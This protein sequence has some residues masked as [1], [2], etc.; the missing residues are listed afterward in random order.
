M[1]SRK[2]KNSNVQ[3]TQQQGS[4]NSSAIGSNKKSQYMTKAEYEQSQKQNSFANKINNLATNLINANERVQEEYRKWQNSPEYVSAMKDAVVENTRQ[5]AGAHRQAMANYQKWQ[6]E[7]Q[8]K[9]QNSPEYVNAVKD[10]IVENSRQRAGY[11]RMQVGNINRRYEQ[12]W[13]NYLNSP[14]YVDYMKNA[15]L[16]NNKQRYANMRQAQAAAYEK[17]KRSPELAETVRDMM[18]E[19]SR[20]QA[21]RQRSLMGLYDW[22]NRSTDPSE[23]YNA[24]SKE[25]RGTWLRPANNRDFNDIVSMRNVDQYVSQNPFDLEAEQQKLEEYKGLK[26]QANEQKRYRT[27]ELNRTRPKKT[28]EELQQERLELV[29]IENQL[30]RYENLDNFGLTYNNG[31]E[32]VTLKKRPDDYDDRTRDEYDIYLYDALHGKGSYDQRMY[33]INTQAETDAFMEEMDDLWD[34]LENGTLHEL[35]AS[36]PLAARKAEILWDT[37]RYDA[38]IEEQDILGRYYQDQIDEQEARI[39]FV[40]GYEDL[41]SEQGAVTMGSYVPENDRGRDDP[42][43][44]VYYYE[45]GVLTDDPHRIY[46]FINKGKEYH[47][48]YAGKEDKD[49]PV[50]SE[51]SYAALMNKEEKEI[52]NDYYN[53]GQYDEAK[54][55]LHGLM[56]YL[57]DR[58]GAYEKI[59]T[60]ETAR[61]YPF[62]SSL[63]IQGMNFADTY[64][65]IPRTVAGWLGD[66]SVDNPN[67]AWYAPAKQAE[68]LQT[69]VSNKIIEDVGERYGKIA[70]NAYQSGMSVVRNMINAKMA[71]ASGL[72]DKAAEVYGL[73]RFG[74]QI[75]QESTYKYLAETHDYNTSVGLGI[76][77]AALETAEEMLPYETMLNNTGRW[78]I[79]VFFNGLSE[80]AEEYTGATVGEKIKGWVRG[81]DEVVKRG[82]EIYMA[83]GYYKDGKWVEIDKADK[84]RAIYEADAQAVREYRENVVS[85]AMGGFLGGS[86]GAA[87]NAQKYQQATKQQGQQIQGAENNYK[88]KSGAD[89]LVELGLQMKP[90]TEARALATEIQE[91]QQK[92]KKP[93]NYKVGKLY[94][95]IYMEVGEQRSA[96]IKETAQRQVRDQLIQKGMTTDMADRFAGI[97]SENILTGEK[98]SKEDMQ[99]LAEDERAIDLWKEYNT[100]AGEEVTNNWKSLI[101]SIEE[102]TSEQDATISRL[103]NMTRSKVAGTSAADAEVNRAIRNTNSSTEAVDYMAKYSS[104]IFSE[105]YAQQAKEILDSDEQAKNSKTFVD[106]AMRIRLA[107]MTQNEQIPDTN[108]SS[109][110]AQ[111][112]Y[113]AARA[114]F[115]ENE[116]LRLNDQTKVTPG[117]GT[118]TFEGTQYGTSAWQEKISQF[119]RNT[120][121]Q[122]GAVAEIARRFGNQVEFINEKDRKMVNG[123]EIGENGQIVIN[124]ASTEWRDHSMM[125]T[126]AHEMTHWLEHNSWEGYNELRGFIISNLRK[127]GMN[128]E[129]ALMNTI[130]NQERVRTE[131][132]ARTGKQSTITTLNIND[133]MAELVAKSSEGILTSNEIKNQLAK[134]NPGLY[135]NVRKAVRNI[136]AR[137]NEAL[138]GIDDSLSEEAKLLRNQTEEIA[139]RWLSAR[140]EALGKEEEGTETAETKQLSV[141]ERKQTIDLAEALKNPELFNDY[142]TYANLIKKDPIVLTDLS[143][144]AINTRSMDK[145]A[146]R[147]AVLNAGVNNAATVGQTKNGMFYVHVGDTGTDVRIN[148]N[149]LRHTY[150]ENNNFELVVEHIGEMINQSVL[151]NTS[152]GREQGQIGS[153]TLLGAGY[154]SDGRIVYAAF[155][156]NRY[157]NQMEDI[158]VL[159]S[160]KRGAGAKLASKSAN[161][162]LLTAP[163]VSIAKAL[164]D[165]KDSFAHLLPID[166]LNKLN[167]E[168]RE[169]KD[170]KYLQH[171]VAQAAERE[172]LQGQAAKHIQ[173]NNQARD[174]ILQ[175]YGIGENDI[176]FGIEFTDTGRV[177]YAAHDDAETKLIRKI[178]KADLRT[179]Y[180]LQQDTEKWQRVWDEDAELMTEDYWEN[181]EDVEDAKRNFGQIYD[182]GYGKPIERFATQV[183]RNG[184]FTALNREYYYSK[185]DDAELDKAYADAVEQGDLKKA[186]GMLIEKLA[187]SQGIVAFRAPH[188]YAGQHREIAKSIKEK[189]GDAIAA[190]V[191]SMAPY[192]PDNAVLIPMPPSSGK[193]IQREEFETD[194][195]VL[196]RALSEATGRPVLIALESDARQSRFK[197]KQAGEKGPVAEE[198]GFRKI[199]DTFGNEIPVFVDNVV[200][201]GETAKA[202]AQAMGGGIT[203]AYAKSTRGTP[204]RGLKN[205]TVTYDENN[206]LIP[207]SKRLDPD[208]PD[209]KYSVEQAAEGEALNV[210]QGDSP[211]DLIDENGNP[212]LTLLPGNTVAQ[213]EFSLSS[214]TELHERS[215]MIKA[216]K[217]A[218]YTEEQIDKWIRDLD[219]I[220]VRIAAD[221]M[222]YDYVADRSKKFLKD[223]GDVYKKTLDASTMCKK[224]RLY[225]GTFN[226]VQHMMPNT[227]LMPEDLI[228][229]YN[230]MKDMDLETPCGFCYVQ[231]RRRHLGTY[232]EEW[233]AEYKGEYIPKVD[234]VTTSDG[235]EKLKKDHP[236]TY[237]DFVA[238]MNN[239]GVNN[240]KLVQQ[241]TDYRGDIRSMRKDTINYLKRIGGL[242]IQSFSDFEVVHMLDMMQAVMDMKAVGL[243]AQAYTKVPEFAWIFGPTGIKINLSLKGQG[244]GV[245]HHGNLIMDN[246]EGIDFDEAMRL[247]Q[248]YPENVGTII[249]GINDDHIITCMGDNRIDFIIPFHKSGWS[250]NEL[251][252]MRGL[253]AY[254]DYT[255][256]QN[257]YDI[258]GRN[259]D[260]SLKIKKAD[261]NLDPLSYWDFSKNGEY[262]AR[263]Y[264]EMC[265]AEKI[266]P[267]FSQF[268]VDNGDGSFSLP[269]GTDQRSTN[270]RTGYW[271]TLIDFRMYDND[272]KG[273]PQRLVQPTFNM[274]AANRILNNYDGSHWEL[275][276]SWEAAEEYVRRYKAAHPLDDVRTQYSVAQ[277]PDM[278]VK[279]FMMGLN[280]FHMNTEQE[281]VMLKQFKELNGQIDALRFKIDDRGKR[282]RALEAKNN[283]SAFDRSELLRL[284]N[285]QQNDQYRMDRLTQEM[286]RV[287]SDKGYAKR[288]YQQ[289]SMM[290]D[291]VTGRSA[292]DLKETVTAMISELDNVTKEMAERAERLK[293]L[294]DAEAVLRIR[295]QFNQKGMHQIALKLKKDMASDLETDIIENRLALIALKMKQGE[296]DIENTQELADMI[297]GKIRQQYDSYI[298]NELKGSTIVLSPLQMKELKGQHRTLKDVRMELAGTGIRISDRGSATLDSKWEDTYCK[299]IPSLKPDENVGNQLD[300]LLNVIRSEKNATGRT[301]GSDEDAMA[302]STAILEAARDLIPEIV[303]DEK[304]LKVIKDTLKFVQELSG[305]AKSS[306]QAME[307]INSLIGRL[308]KTGASAS[309]SANKLTGDIQDAIK[310][311]NDLAEQ[312]EAAKWKRERILL[313]EQLKSENTQKILEEQE[314]WKKRIERDKNVREMMDSNMQLR[315]KITTNYGRIRKLLIAETDQKNIP[316]H[317]KSLARYMLGL[318]TEND[319]AN[320][321]I[322]GFSA[323]DLRETKRVLDIMNQQDGIFSIDDLRMIDDEEA[324]AA[325]AEALADLEDGIGFYNASTGKDVITNLQAFRNS[326]DRINEAVITITNVINAERTLSFW[327]RRME[328]SD[329]ATIISNDMSRS[330]FKGELEG[331]GSKAIKAAKS[332][333][334][335]GNTTPVYF[336]KNLLNRGMD[337]LWKDTEQSENRNGL[338][339]QKAKDYLDSL[340]KKTNYKEWADKTYTV[341]LGGRKTELSIENMMELYAIWKRE[342]KTNPEMSQHLTKGGVYFETEE[343]QKGRL[344][345][346]RKQQRAIR[347]TDEEIAAMAAQMTDQQ[348]EYMEGMVSFLSNEMSA[349][350][351]EASMRMYGIKK[352]KES[353]YF[354]M[355]VWDGVKSVR[356]DRGISGTDENRA[357]HKSWSKR[358][359]H[360]AKNALVIGNFTNDAVKHIVEMINYN[361]MAPAIENMNKVLNYQFTEGETEADATKR[362][363]RVMFTEAYGKEALRYLKTFLQDLNGGVTQDQRKTLRDRLISIFKKNAVAGSLSV[364]LQ[365]PL[366][367]IRAAMMINPVYL[368][369]A[370][371]PIYWKGSYREMMDYS[372]VAVI[373]N[374]GRFDMNFGQ[375]AKDYITPETKS[376]AYE[377]VSDLLTKAPELMDRM[378]WTRMWSAVKMEQHAKHKGMDV[379]SDAFLQLVAD[380]FN[381]VMRRTQV[382]DSILVK[383]SNMRSTNP[384]MKI[385]TSFMAE[386]TLSINV[387]ADAIRPAN[388][389]QKGGIENLA[390]AGAT[391][392]LSAVCQAAVKAAMGSGRSPDKKKTWLENFLNKLQTSLMSEINPLGLIPGYSDIIEALK[393]GELKDDAMGVIGKLKTI[394][395]KTQDWIS[396]KNT[397][398]YRNIEDTIGQFVQLFTNIPAKNL[399]RDARAMYNW[400]TGEP[401][402]KRESSAGVIRYQAEANAFTGDNLIS[403]VNKWLGDAGF[404]TSNTSYYQRLYQAKKNGNEQ[405]ADELYDYLALGK[406]IKDATIRSNVAKAAK[407]DATM[408]EA[409]R[410]AWM[411]TEGNVSELGYI[412]NQYKGGL[413]TKAEAAKLM[414]QLDPEITEDEIFWKLDRVDWANETG[415]DKVP[416]SYDYRL[417]D[418]IKSNKAEQINEVVTQMMK[419]GITQ[420]KIKRYLSDWKSEYLAAEGKEKVRIR[421]AI[422]KAYKA[423]GYTV[424]EADKLFERWNKEK[425]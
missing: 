13:Q 258:I 359:Q 92:G 132:K 272:G 420:E 299:L 345:H 98:L 268:L 348:K 355:K 46:S 369:G 153:Y 197:A 291:L 321:K 129:A 296:F 334:V 108:M 228:D 343:E 49:K 96:V 47:G 39:R 74:L 126:L 237:M 58:Y 262:N 198:M 358:R 156:I 229:L 375:S 75:Y 332:M 216:L 33:D 303:T 175:K 399:M 294:G 338:E 20:Q 404:Q 379:K 326:L 40:Q 423:A 371:N 69:E 127:N 121:N 339:T 278:D 159:D 45:H 155:R 5:R 41:M 60:A 366:S 38:G 65:A 112:L 400:I 395:E 213:T 23:R 312:S 185:W 346:E 123:W 206:N 290:N 34:R 134:E 352:Y 62:L 109:E 189:Y 97:I 280:E 271:K 102:N 283:K 61:S 144:N 203:L 115:M 195:L 365:Q 217:K 14:E 131:E 252:K 205:L 25:Q 225:N 15:T 236:Q 424:E 267:K 233:L 350:G 176:M 412:T 408:T 313:I 192:V 172:A 351:N 409:E 407:D 209:V 306:A 324:Q 235:L 43:S 111:K 57:Q 79:D 335:S 264:L 188:G 320:R 36:S 202:A 337:L 28:E 10:A 413:L 12:E 273:A 171:S 344:R 56:P 122:M 145:N 110:S 298:I 284:K 422:T 177:D 275:P 50:T 301:Y 277:A 421:D 168:R 124:V 151:I 354:P 317:M 91:Q 241:R 107:A 314:K 174:L 360:M 200:G 88:G 266:V 19:V 142:F 292:E 309:K 307:E 21:G 389:K 67:S 196:S 383:S 340:A 31:D 210:E 85:Q 239:K 406:G 106:D 116:K 113:D 137:V 269:E 293:S 414:K 84:Q 270:I 141:T 165:V 221:R 227:I 6:Q 253:D 152:S 128:V 364:A 372:G 170:S 244:V 143:K 281:R 184:K 95:E 133:A 18:P 300:A 76:L 161:S 336:F 410:T 223:N 212:V 377:K 114:E 157:T 373:K 193:V 245:D 386:P 160:I 27:D 183:I 347:V 393:N 173:M 120:R 256:S 220:A 71:M 180:E 425:K 80:A 325:V 214:Y 254:K 51:Y 234:E 257:E 63:A 24:L 135:E 391:F 68:R 304:S 125:A 232:T 230:I 323:K 285:I 361:T 259:E 255:A 402:P 104:N 276:E 260:G 186:E 318:I 167:V 353:Y 42:Y 287:T 416:T 89:Q 246:D 82:D 139:K 182:T 147:K 7:Q 417:K 146:A 263:K 231:S 140:E 26:E 154:K 191:E 330:R 194:T 265:K 249:V 319:L 178:S 100:G 66:K 222:R 315:K 288:M 333:I 363:V 367:Y 211:V 162:L 72:T 322:T 81:R 32:E 8:Q 190:A 398:V 418:A 274:D 169:N 356:S 250:E 329:V 302:V 251:K 240:P 164:N 181:A 201:K 289:S 316:E 86:V 59:Y 376:G 78:Y 297:V 242:R 311:F 90:G 415:A 148:K 388:L 16:E 362:N 208:N 349:L 382:Y 394:V 83:G 3:S 64:M 94:Q 385:A 238:A 44:D 286:V 30:G 117:K 105:E 158:D 29:E 357:A 390:K 380:R 305:E 219:S 310:Y 87:F 55:F 370:L 103:E 405:E 70:A 204:V 378:T 179:L 37:Q 22:M 368:A 73:A 387:L 2:K 392:I 118:A 295:Q 54:A 224:T 101:T 130:R 419:H 308:K 149:G 374:M 261:G 401:Y 150:E 11:Q 327:E 1:A 187:R 138:K 247:R 282:I 226:L 279:R 136:V 403:V 331:R 411:I 342:Q 119:N 163:T 328:V 215:K 4:T 17:W 384:L 52:F 218:G 396:G 93:S 243:T 207:L 35:T 397:D 166:V 381:E 99:I 53:S 9:W 199:N 248:A 48:W 77:D 341:T